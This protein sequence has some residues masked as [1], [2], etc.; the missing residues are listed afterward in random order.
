MVLGAFSARYVRDLKYTSLN[1]G[2]I[3]QE[4][5]GGSS[6]GRGPYGR[7]N[8]WRQKG[9]HRRLQ[10]CETLFFNPFSKHFRLETC[11]TSLT[12][13]TSAFFRW[14]GVIFPTQLISPLHL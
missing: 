12:R 2:W 7:D 8:H 5:L 13:I 11:K 9:A 10:I 14:A 4:N 3:Q 1:Q 6:I